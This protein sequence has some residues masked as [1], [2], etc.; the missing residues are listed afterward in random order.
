[1]VQADQL[2]SWAALQQ[3]HNTV[4]KS[5]V[6][7]EEF[8]KDPSRF[9]KFS[10][11]FDNTADKSEILFDF[12]KN[13]LTEETLKL[14]VAVA[15]E[16]K[17]EELRD[18]MFSG[19][20]I[21]FTEDRAVLHT[22]L[23]NV[24]NEVVKVDG[25]DVMPGVNKELDHME[26]FSE[27]VRS[28]EWKGFTGKPLTTIINIGIGGS[29]LSVSPFQ[30]GSKLILNSGPVMVTEALKYYGDRKMTLHFVS[31]ID[32]T[33]MAE[34]LRDSDPETTLFLIASKTFTTAETTTNA[35]SAK[36]WFLE[37]TDGKGDIAKHFV[38]LST[39]EKEVTKFGIDAKNMFGFESWVGGRYSVWSA[40][41]LSVALYIG[42]KNFH[43]FLEGAHAMDTHFRTTP[44]E[45]NIPVI[46]GL[47]SVWYS[48]FYGAQTHLVSP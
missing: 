4:G 32:G 17:I 14:L 30:F 26:E 36:D 1:M 6:L 41:G 25:V 31:N 10:F 40:I 11:T 43:S 35:H 7:K 34:A 2:S 33:H 39:N 45:K 20:K 15:K 21:N 3:H 29:D 12:S 23:R 19:D 42:F 28:G 8:K 47:L 48:D 9:S 37:K 13:F 38:A 27:A 24:T 46:A 18:A 44:L 22:A 16:A 5:F